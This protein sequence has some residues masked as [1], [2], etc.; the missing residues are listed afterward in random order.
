MAYAKQASTIIE[1]AFIIF[2]YIAQQNRDLRRATEDYKDLK[3]QAHAPVFLAKLEVNAQVQKILKKK[4][5]FADRFRRSHHTKQVMKAL[6]AYQTKKKSSKLQKVKAVEFM[7]L[8]TMRSTFSEWKHYI[9]SRKLKWQK[10]Q[11]MYE[12]V[13]TIDQQNLMQKTFDAIFQNLI[14]QADE[15]QWAVDHLT[16]LKKERMF[17]R[18]EWHKDN[19]LKY[20]ATQEL[21]CSKHNLQQQLKFFMLWRTKWMQL[22]LVKAHTMNKEKRIVQKVWKQFVLHTADCRKLKSFM[23]IKKFAKLDS[24]FQQLKENVDRKYCKQQL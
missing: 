1:R 22:N 20:Q 15:Q 6:I 11:M 24:C 14:R 17:R 10:R 21:I 4:L 16:Y 7:L 13:K 5:E 19:N 18:L 23:A 3:I 8:R 9:D 2:K 12:V